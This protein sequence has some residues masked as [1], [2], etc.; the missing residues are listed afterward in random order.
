MRPRT[1]EPRASNRSDRFGRCGRSPS[2][3]GN[4]LIEIGFFRP[5]PSNPR[6]AR[7]TR[8]ETEGQTQRW[9]SA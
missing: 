6:F 9:L 2:R 5:S 7:S 8:G 4:P 1:E 3:Q